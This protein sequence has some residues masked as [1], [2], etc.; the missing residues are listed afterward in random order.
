MNAPN[1]F[2]PAL[3][4]R[5]SPNGRLPLPTPAEWASSVASRSAPSRTARATERLTILAGSAIEGRF[6]GCVRSGSKWP[7]RQMSETDTLF[8]F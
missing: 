3:A 4:S 6:D 5:D 1:M 8:G 7:V 2:A